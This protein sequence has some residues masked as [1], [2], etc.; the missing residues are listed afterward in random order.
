MYTVYCFRL[1]AVT[2]IFKTGQKLEHCK[3]CPIGKYCKMAETEPNS[4]SAG[5]WCKG[6]E[7]HED[8]YSFK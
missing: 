1:V 2:T 6:S 5:Y 7:F 3:D 4:C 8:N